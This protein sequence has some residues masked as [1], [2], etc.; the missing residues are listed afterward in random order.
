MAE[1]R[2]QPGFT[3]TE[4]I[5]VVAVIT[6]LVG[7]AFPSFRAIWRMGARTS[8]LANLR[9]VAIALRAYLDRS[10][11]IMPVAAQRPSLQL[12]DHPSIAEVLRPHLG[13]TD[14]LKCPADTARRYFETEGSS[15]E[16]QCIHAGRSVEEG[17]LTRKLG[18]DRTPVMND[19]EPFHGRPGTPGA[20]NFLFADGHVGG[21]D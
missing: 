15:Y 10:S 8:C 1:K 7:L 14:A 21:L 3:L 13:G 17:F 6:A 5:V 16:Y 18:A 4:L 11:D 12:N 2:A 9:S 20:V 19:Y